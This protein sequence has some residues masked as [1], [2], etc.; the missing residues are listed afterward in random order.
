M[1][2]ERALARFI[3]FFADTVR[4]HALGQ[5]GRGDGSEANEAPPLVRVFDKLSDHQRRKN[6][7]RL[8]PMARTIRSL[9][10]VKSLPGQ[11]RTVSRCAV[12]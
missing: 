10:I 6:A 2:S 4:I 9:R 8:Y 12:V 3:P 1:A 5:Q 11:L 7:C